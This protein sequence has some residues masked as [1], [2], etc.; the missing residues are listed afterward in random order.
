M[1]YRPYNDENFILI[2]LLGYSSDGFPFVG[3]IPNMDGVFI[4]AS[5]QGLGMVL[6]FMCAKALVQIMHG[7]DEELKSWFPESFR[8]TEPRMKKKFKGRLHT[9]TA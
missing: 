8:I 9:G 5:F 7:Q 3:E 2:K 4:S 6:C 1:R